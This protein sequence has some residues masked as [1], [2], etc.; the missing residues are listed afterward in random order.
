ME[1]VT[2]KRLRNTSGIPDHQVKTI[3]EW[4]AGRLGISQFDV[5]CRSSRSA[6][7][8]RAYTTGAKE[9]HGNRRPFVVLRIGTETIDRWTSDNGK[10]ISLRRS[11]LGTAHQATAVKVS[12]RRFPT[13]V[14][15]YQYAH[16]KNK[17]YVL[18]NRTEALVYLAAHELRHLWQAARLRDDRKS[19]NLPM[20]HG[21]RGKFS[22]VDTE[23]FAI[24]MLREYRRLEAQAR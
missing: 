2:L 3:I 1:G 4:I 16:H 24:T 22:E 5:E 23:G 18:R 6:F 19:A 10:R 8:G 17:R 21:S 13:F 20:Y 7:A 12:K 15:P 11:W 9:Y 14:Q